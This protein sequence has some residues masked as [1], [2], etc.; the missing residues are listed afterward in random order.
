MLDYTGLDESSSQGALA[1]ESG[2]KLEEQVSEDLIR[3]LKRERVPFRHY[4]HSDANAMLEEW[5]ANRLL[6]ATHIILEQ[7]QT[8]VLGILG[9]RIRTDVYCIDPK[10]LTHA[11]IESVRKLHVMMPQEYVAWFAEMTYPY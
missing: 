8:G 4:R 6:A 1:N 11:A 10:G 9:N 3:T 5:R 2:R 7:V